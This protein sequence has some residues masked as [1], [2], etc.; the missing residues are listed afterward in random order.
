MVIITLV[1]GCQVWPNSVRKNALE[2]F[3]GLLHGIYA[4]AWTGQGT[5][6]YHQAVYM[7]EMCMSDEETAMAV[8]FSWTARGKEVIVTTAQRNISQ[9][10][11]TCWVRPRRGIRRGEDSPVESGLTRLGL[12]LRVVLVALMSSTR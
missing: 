1:P 4:F 9:R 8:N 7:V 5:C 2:V 6:G 3:K 12:S 11:K 10:P